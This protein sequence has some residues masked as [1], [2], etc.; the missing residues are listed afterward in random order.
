MEAINGYS[1]YKHFVLNN[2]SQDVIKSSQ[3]TAQQRNDR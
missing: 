2:S 3:I 1:F